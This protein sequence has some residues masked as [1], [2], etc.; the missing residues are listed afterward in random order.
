MRGCQDLPMARHHEAA[1]SAPENRTALA[2]LVE[3]ERV[4]AAFL[5]MWFEE[6]QAM[7]AA[8][9]TQSH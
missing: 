7:L 1:M 5:K 8:V 2:N 3:R 4:L 6:D 9:A